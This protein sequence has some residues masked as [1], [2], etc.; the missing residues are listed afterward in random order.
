MTL[1][2]AL[3]YIVSWLI[4]SE[5]FHITAIHLICKLQMIGV[6]NLLLHNKTQQVNSA[7]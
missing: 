6:D 4:I 5:I 1:Y 7:S 2:S 3:E